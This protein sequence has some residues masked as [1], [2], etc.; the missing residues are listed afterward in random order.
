MRCSEAGDEELGPGRP[1]LLAPLLP[2]LQDTFHMLLGLEGDLRD[3]S[4]ARVLLS[5]IHI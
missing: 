1:G 5:L 3:R 2:S 4:E